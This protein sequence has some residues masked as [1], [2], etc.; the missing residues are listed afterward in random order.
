[1]EPNRPCL[2]PSAPAPWQPA[3][4]GTAGAMAAASAELAEVSSSEEGESRQARGEVAG[5][6]QSWKKSE[7]VEPCRRVK[8]IL[9][10]ETCFWKEKCHVKYPST[11][12]SSAEN[13][14]LEGIRNVEK[15]FSIGSQKQNRNRLFLQPQFYSRHAGNKRKSQ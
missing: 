9:E 8:E 15:N 7:R 12:C 10:E 13:V 6:W 14:A 3:R 1:M 4:P 5:G 11:D 2:S